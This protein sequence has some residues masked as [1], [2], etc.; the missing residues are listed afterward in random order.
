MAKTIELKHAVTVG[1]LTVKEITLQRPK[2]K[3][4][5]AIG[6]IPYH[7][8]EADARLLASISGLPEKVID[9]IDIEDLAILRIALARI[10]TAYF[11]GNPYIEDP[12]EAEPAKAPQNGTGEKEHP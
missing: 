6:T 4:F 9:Q 10:W 12:T 8:V 5:I 11:S 1:E 7:C 2:T 3:D